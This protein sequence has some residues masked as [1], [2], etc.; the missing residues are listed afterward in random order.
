MI[1]T[2]RFARTGHQ[3][4]RTI[5][6]A[7]ALWSVS[8][9]QADRVLEV[10]LEHGVNHIDTAPSY[11]DSELRVGPWMAEHRG[12]FFLGTKADE[13]TRDGAREQIRRSLERLQV[14]GVDLIQLHN[15]VD[16]DEWDTAMGS[17]GA[18]EAVIEAR[19]EGLVRFIGVTG[20]GVTVAAQHLRALERF[21]FDSV[22]LPYSFVLM[23]NPAYAA[24]FDALMAVCDER[25]V[26]VQTI[27]SLARAPWDD[28]AQTR[29]TWYE[30]LEDQPDIDLAVH[31][32]LGCSGVFLNTAGDVDVLPRVLDA[33][34]RFQ[35]RP[36][37]VEMQQLSSSR[38]M[39]P[40]FT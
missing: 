11:G 20:H 5:F 14:D 26:A 32:V 8:Q 1:A 27:K 34:E 29:T 39:V 3:S 25:D 30:P 15:L 36:D 35:T 16:A 6:G 22:L 18:L 2:S 12:D 19:D 7:A 17:G 37:D 33:A 28:R 31:W 21:D 10:L 24:D 23:Q 4:S 9:A 40:L 13:R 38:D